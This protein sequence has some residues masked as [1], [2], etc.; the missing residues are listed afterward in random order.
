MAL[1][2]AVAVLIIALALWDWQRRLQL[3]WA[4]G[5]AAEMGAFHKAM[6]YKL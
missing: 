4:L 5:R 1:I 6:H 3:W 2:N